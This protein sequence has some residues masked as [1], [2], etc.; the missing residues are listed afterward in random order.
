MWY[1]FFVA[2]PIPA[3]SILCRYSIHLQ[4]TDLS[5]ELY[6]I[7][8]CFYGF[9]ATR[10]PDE[11]T[12]L[13]LTLSHNFRQ[14]EIS[15]TSLLLWDLGWAHSQPSKQPV[16]KFSNA[17]NSTH[18]WKQLRTTAGSDLHIPHKNLMI[19]N[20]FPYSHVNNDPPLITQLYKCFYIRVNCTRLFLWENYS[21]N[22]NEAAVY[23]SYSLLICFTA[24]KWLTTWKIDTQFVKLLSY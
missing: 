5:F 2:L 7:P 12:H 13:L 3:H 22:N 19:Q 18:A 23:K 16:Q 8:P 1:F 24:I 9:S 14:E 11:C 6:S 10:S 15:K 4:I 21:L 17:I 20:S